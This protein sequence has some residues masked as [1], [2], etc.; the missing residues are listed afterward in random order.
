MKGI[1]IASVFI[2]SFASFNKAIANKGEQIFKTNC[3]ACHSVG[4]GKLVGPDLKN[5]NSRHDEAW[6]LKWIKSSQTL[7]KSG[8]KAAIQLYNDNANL[9]MQDF[10]LDD[11]QIR[12]VLAYI[13]EKENLIHE[14]ASSQNANDANK[15]ANQKNKELI[16]ASL[17]SMLGFSGY[18]L[19]ML[20]GLL[21]IIIWVMSMSI[22]KLAFDLKEKNKS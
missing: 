16:N 22:K 3:G 18:I 7:I 4:K 6:L 17:L 15:P 2:F 1:I 21:M 11:D 19:F 13:R 5:V 14:V 9:V 20:I 8:D 12:S 10:D